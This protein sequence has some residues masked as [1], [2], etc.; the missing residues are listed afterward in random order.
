MLGRYVPKRLPAYTVLM[1]LLAFGL[2]GFA[3]IGRR[4][5]SSTFIRAHV[6]IGANA[7]KTKMRN[8]I[9]GAVAML[10]APTVGAAQPVTNGGVSGTLISVGNESLT[11]DFTTPTLT[12][13]STPR[14]LKVTLFSPR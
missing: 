8:W 13:G 9:A 3:V 1:T 14:P 6:M 2:G 7:M 10:L 12:S 11:C 5:I 4:E